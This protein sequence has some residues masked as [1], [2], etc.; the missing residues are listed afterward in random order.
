MEH[1]AAYRCIFK[2]RTAFKKTHDLDP[3]AAYRCFSVAFIGIV[4]ET[5][6]RGARWLMP[7]MLLPLFHWQWHAI[8]AVAQLNADEDD[9]HGGLIGDDVDHDKVTIS[10][11]KFLGWANDR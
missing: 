7:G 5:T 11:S 8:F 6:Y 10:V 1:R 4:P 9:L 3:K 2:T